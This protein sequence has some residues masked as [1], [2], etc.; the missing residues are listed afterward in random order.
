[1]LIYL[2]NVFDLFVNFTTILIF[3]RVL[4]S[5]FNIKNRFA[6]VIFDLTE[7]VLLPIRNILPKS[8]LLDFSPIVAFLLL[9]GLQ[10]LVHF[11]AN[12]PFN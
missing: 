3:I 4:L 9:Q 2:V 10:Y 6:Q 8:T 12:V 1:M 11:L 7:P 5:W